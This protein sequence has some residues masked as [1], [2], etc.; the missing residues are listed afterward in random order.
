MSKKD[1]SYKAS[2]LYLE[3]RFSVFFSFV[4]LTSIIEFHAFLLLNHLCIAE[5]KIKFCLFACYKMFFGISMFSKMILKWN[6]LNYINYIKLR[7]TSAIE[8]NNVQV[9]LVPSIAFCVLCYYK[10]LNNSFFL[11]QER[12][13]T[14]CAHFQFLDYCSSTSCL[15]AISS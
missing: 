7:E 4:N 9:S 12:K 15:K 6:L 14:S 1:N 11:F 13:G 2:I 5:L 3:M 8:Y 10:L